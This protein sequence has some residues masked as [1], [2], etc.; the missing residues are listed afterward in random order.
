VRYYW[1]SFSK[2]VETG[3]GERGNVGAMVVTARD[4]ENLEP[5]EILDRA[6]ELGAPNSASVMGGEI[7]Q[8]TAEQYPLDVLIS[9]EKLREL[10]EQGKLAAVTSSAQVCSDCADA[11]NE[12]HGHA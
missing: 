11:L 12:E 10:V 2:L 9:P 8:A 5:Q 1:L 3:S 7:D 6:L 4:D